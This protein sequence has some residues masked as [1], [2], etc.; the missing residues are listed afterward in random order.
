MGHVEYDVIIYYV[1]LLYTYICIHI[2]IH[3]HIYIHLHTHVGPGRVSFKTVFRL[4]SAT[5]TS[6][7]TLYICK[8]FTDI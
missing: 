5:N 7:P 1:I 4:T 6:S 3:I 2:H 8:P